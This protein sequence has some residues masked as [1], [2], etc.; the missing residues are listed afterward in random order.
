MERL[1]SRRAELLGAGARPLGWK[2]AFGPPAAHEPL[3]LDG[4]VVGFLTDATLLASGGACA[5]GGWTAPKLEPELAI[6]VGAPVEPGAGPEAAAAA[7]TGLSAAI[8]L[9]DADLPPAELEAVLAGDVY[10]RRVVLGDGIAG[11]PASPIAVEV[12]RDGEP[13]AS[14]ADAEAAT[15]ALSDLIAYVACY[16]S[17][18]GAALVPG[19]VVISGS[20]VPLIDIA[21]GQRL[22]SVVAG[23]GAAEVVLG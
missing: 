21:P 8:E 14:S 11:L 10:H 16:L 4:P 22:R 9:A 7:I 15:G 12:E 3:G 2:L 19:D 18:F 1:L 13:L 20:T 17:E 23:V 6:H 5:V